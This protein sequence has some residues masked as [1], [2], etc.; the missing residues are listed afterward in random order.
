ME[1]PDK[2]P[3]ASQVLAYEGLKHQNKVLLQALSTEVQINVEA[4][5]A[6]VDRSV[7]VVHHRDQIL[8]MEHRQINISPL[9]VPVSMVQIQARARGSSVDLRHLLTEPLISVMN[10]LVKV[11]IIAN[12]G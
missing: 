3:Q 2:Y 8:L 12:Q 6:Q 1:Y 7:D 11:K 9:A 10:S 4:M 5:E